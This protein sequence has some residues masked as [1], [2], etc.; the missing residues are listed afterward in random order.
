MLLLITERIE[1]KLTDLEARMERMEDMQREILAILTS[2]TRTRTNNTTNNTAIYNTNTNNLNSDDSYNTNTDSYYDTETD[3]MDIID[4]FTEQ[5]DITPLCI[6]TAP[7]PTC[8]VP[9][10]LP[11]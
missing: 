7:L 5:I 1:R 6:M 8:T 10:P 11:T 4:T 3:I 2:Q 9:T